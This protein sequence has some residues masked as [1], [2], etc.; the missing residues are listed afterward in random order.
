M[1]CRTTDRGNIN[2][3]DVQTKFFV[4]LLFSEKKKNKIYTKNK[5]CMEYRVSRIDSAE[6]VGFIIIFF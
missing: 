2:E 3:N 4:S 5:S 1:L 6:A